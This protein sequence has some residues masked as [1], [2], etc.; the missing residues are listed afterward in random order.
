MRRAR[1]ATP[2]A[3]PGHVVRYG[4]RVFDTKRH[5][6]YEPRGKRAGPLRCGS[7]GA[8][9][10]KGRWQWSDIPGAATLDACPA[11]ER[12][13]DKMPAGWITLE[14]PLVAA[15]GDELMRI[16]LNEATHE[17]GEHPLHRVIDT[18]R[19]GDRVEI[20]TTD[21]HLPQRIGRAIQRAH[22]GALVIRYG[23]NEYSVRVHWRG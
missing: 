18:V 16:A 11:C 20:A 1:L 5:D 7:C 6:P 22:H 14:G 2:D 19:H 4:A 12:T 13:R 3:P 9:Y 23:S 10:R 8:A 21:V 15:R 17:R